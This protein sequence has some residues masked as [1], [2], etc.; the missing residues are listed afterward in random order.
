MFADRRPQLGPRRGVDQP[1]ATP[2]GV[3]SVAAV[4][5]GDSLTVQATAQITAKIPTAVIDAQVGRTLVRPNLTDEGLS[6]VP[7]LVSIDAAWFVVELGTNDS[8]FGASPAIR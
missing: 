6:R 2:S 5:L 4:V 7:E 3:H 8:T 1:P